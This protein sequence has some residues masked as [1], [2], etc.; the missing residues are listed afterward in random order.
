[1]IGAATSLRTELSPLAVLT[2]LRIPAFFVNYV[3]CWIVFCLLAGVILALDR[4]KLQPEWCQYVRFLCVPWK[5]VLF[6][7]AFLFVT[8]AGRFTDD[9]T[10]DIV[11]GSGMALLT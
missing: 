2:F 4:K 5:L 1:M 8:L 3:A 10:R 11:T 9:E 7:P 6:V